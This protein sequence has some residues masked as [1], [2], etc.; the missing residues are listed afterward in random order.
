MH[1][2]FGSD[3]L[4]S[5]VQYLESGLH[6]I[7]IQDWNCVFM[8]L[9]SGLSSIGASMTKISQIAGSGLLD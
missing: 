6:E 2:F 8:R 7:A 4:P 1:R 5:R 3:E 9:T